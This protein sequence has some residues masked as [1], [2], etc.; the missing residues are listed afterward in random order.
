M[1]LIFLKYRKMICLFSNCNI[2]GNP[3]DRQLNN[4]ILNQVLASVLNHPLLSA[5]LCINLRTKPCHINWPICLFN[6]VVVQGVNNLI[7]YKDGIMKLHN[8][9][10]QKG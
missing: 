6:T 5:N 8:G 2:T 3:A 7:V 10:N 1:K 4:C 9:A